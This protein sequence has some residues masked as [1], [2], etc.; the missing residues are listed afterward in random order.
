[1][2]QSLLLHRQILVSGDPFLCLHVS[3]FGWLQVIVDVSVD[4][5]LYV[6]S[7]CLSIR[8]AKTLR[9][10]QLETLKHCRG[11]PLLPLKHSNIVPV[12]N[13]CLIKTPGKIRPLVL[14]NHL[15]PASFCPSLTWQYPYHLQ[16][17][18]LSLFV[19]LSSCIGLVSLRTNQCGSLC[20]AH[21][22]PRPLTERRL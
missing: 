17:Q 12:C 4:S 6:T 15:I 11:L 18:V 20:I 10:S 22:S 14:I 19:P 5:F 21:D 13:K 1:M 3:S 9:S 2:S 16:L 7:A 8:N